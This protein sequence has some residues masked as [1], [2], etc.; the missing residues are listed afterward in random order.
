MSEEV[1]Y[2]ETYG[3]EIEVQVPDHDHAQGEHDLD[4]EKTE[5]IELEIEYRLTWEMPDSRQVE[6]I[7]HRYGKN[8]WGKLAP[9]GW[10]KLAWRQTNRVDDRFTDIA[11]QAAQ[12][13]LWANTHEQPIRNVILER[14]PKNV[15]G[16]EPVI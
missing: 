5:E 15:S 16:W 8:I 10:D 9:D 14:R 13:Q 11:D 4:Y 6:I 7:E 12:L 1:P 2:K 3:G